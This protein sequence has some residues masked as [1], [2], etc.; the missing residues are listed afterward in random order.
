MEVNFSKLESA[1]NDFVLIEDDSGLSDYNG[2]AIQACNRHFGI[3]ADGVLV[4]NRVSSE[5]VGMRV[6]NADGSEAEACGNGLRCLVKYALDNK[7][8]DGAGQPVTVHTIAG[9]RTAR[10]I[11]KTP[12]GTRI[13]TSMGKPGFAPADIPVDLPAEIFTEKLDIKLLSPVSIQL[14]GVELELHF[15]SMGNPHAVFFTREPVTR[16]PLD[17]IGPLVEHHNMF[18]KK[19]NFE[20]ARVVSPDE[21]EVRVWERGVG[22]TLACGSGACATGVVAHLLGFT[23]KSATIH[24]PGGMLTVKWVPTSEVYLQGTARTVFTGTILL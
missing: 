13:E 5:S 21:I 3:G 9:R 4:I 16:F 24:L 11:E 12:D 14:G 7:F 10:V 8:V 19:T 6:F 18:P 15:A 20:V 23:G 2:F 17:K 1:G 22:E